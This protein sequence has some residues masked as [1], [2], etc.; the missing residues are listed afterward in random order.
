M[1][2]REPEISV[3]VFI[4]YAH[5]DKEL[6]QRLEEHLSSLKYSGEIVVWQDQEIPAGANW[7]DQINTHLDEADL[8]LL[9]ISASF[10]ASK[11]CWNKEVQ[12]ALLRHG[13]GTAQV[14]PIILRPIVWQ[15]TPLGQLQ[16]LPVGAKPVTQWSDPDAA[17]ENVVQ[18][19]RKVVEG[20]ILRREVAK[21]EEL[22]KLVNKIEANL[23][24]ALT[25][26]NQ[27]IVEMDNRIGQQEQRKQELVEELEAINVSIKQLKGRQGRAEDKQYQLKKELE[28]TSEQFVKLGGELDVSTRLFLAPPFHLWQPLYPSA[29]LL[30]EARNLNFTK[31]M[32]GWS[33]TGE[34][35]QDYV[36]RVGFLSMGHGVRY[37][38]SL[39]AQVDQPAAFG[40][41]AQA[42]QGIAYRGKRLR[43]S[44]LVQAEG[45]EQWAGLWMRVDG[46]RGKLLSFDNMGKRPIR[47]TVEERRYEVVL[48]VSTESIGINFGILLLGKGEVWLSDVR[49]E[50]VGGDIA[51]TDRL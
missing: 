34:A 42:F 6:R 44:G 12:A 49:F 46:E 19:I 38:V 31:G 35:P 29:S 11:Y 3:R 30:R 21:E 47:G 8:I 5:A 36:C 39:K 48:D 26:I 9:L 40:T 16:A 23:Q 25:S 50:V 15:N 2:P 37:N 10:I 17:L 13:A 33:L 18:G 4:S 45:V 22:E 27:S 24:P 28:E 32:Q 43:L 41:L 1:L 51:T 14:I 20:I 7:E